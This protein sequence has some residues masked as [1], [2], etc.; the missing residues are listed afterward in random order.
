VA[1]QHI[2]SAFPSNSCVSCY[3]QISLILLVPTPFYLRLM[4]FYVFEY[5]S[6]RDRKRATAVAG[7]S[8]SFE[9]SLIHYFTPTHGVFIVMYLVYV[10][11]AV[12]LAFMSRSSKEHRIKK[13]V[14]ESFKDLKRLNWTDTLS[15]LVLNVI[16]PFKRYGLLGC[17]VGLAYWPI[18]VP[19]SLAISA[20]YFIPTIYLTV[21]M[22]FHSKI[23]TVVKAR[24]SHRKTYKVRENV[25]QDMYRFETDN[26]I[27][28]LTSEEETVTH[29][30][31]I[32]LDDLD[33]IKP[34]E[35][36]IEPDEVSRASTIIYNSF[37]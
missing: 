7:L 17:F 3:Y 6:L 33:H 24:R 8:E 4:V 18:A 30:S 36:M 27:S 37:R 1:R 34:A 23:A 15:M 10:A 28:V 9:N 26:V 12:V 20:A 29:E 16:W 35:H 5:D 32:S 11:M 14:V 31:T 13:I 22:A 2:R 25:D 19:V 21:R